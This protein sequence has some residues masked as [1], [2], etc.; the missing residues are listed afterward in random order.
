M[1][2]IYYRKQ[3]GEMS[4]IIVG[5][6]HKPTAEYH[7]KLGLPKSMLVTTIDH[8]YEIGHTSI[9]DIIE[10]SALE[11]ILK[12]ADEVYWAESSKN[13]F[14]DNA[15]YYD[16]LDWLKD[17]NL[18]Y[19]NVKN[20]DLIKFDPYNWKILLPE[21]TEQSMIFFGS[22]TT[23]GFGIDNP[24]QQYVNLV[25]KYFKKTPINVPKIYNT[26]LNSNDKIF[27]LFFQFNFLPGQLVVLHIAPLTRI[28]Y[29]T[30]DHQLIDLQL[31]NKILPN[32]K[33]LVQ[34]YI[35][36]FLF[37]NL[38]IKLT[39]MIKFAREKKL[40]VVF[41]LDDYKQGSISEK[42]Q[43]Y[44]YEFPEYIPG[45]QLKNDMFQDK[46]NDGVHPGINANWA[47]AQEVINHMENLYK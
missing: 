27:D 39:A 3:V 9:Q 34:V 18:K 24:E 37:Y 32:H 29:C 19:K 4:V 8:G 22:S 28:R 6:N 42:D 47:I 11:V 23:A 10:S 46:A 2:E 44:F 16:F 17:Y 13:E 31:S 43:Q 26:S 1:L 25:A 20:F 15:S 30:T 21:V 14:F 40:R 41:F 36:E 7:K 33:Q 12:N 45:S 38:Y 5:S 35:E